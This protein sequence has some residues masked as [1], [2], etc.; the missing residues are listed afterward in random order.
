MM[1]MLYL[2]GAVFASIASLALA[3]EPSLPSLPRAFRA[4]VEANIVNKKYTTA[5]EEAYDYDANSVVYVRDVVSSTGEAGKS[6]SFHDLDQ[7]Q[8]WKWFEGLGGS[9]AR[10]CS[11]EYTDHLRLEAE[12][13]SSTHHLHLKGTADFFRFGA[14]F[15]QRFVGTS[16]VRG[17][18]AKWWRSEMSHSSPSRNGK[19]MV[20]KNYSLD[21]Y[22][23]DDDWKMSS[24]GSDARRLD[25]AIGVPLKL[26][27]TG[28]S[29]PLDKEAGEKAYNFDHH[30]D[31]FS[32]TRQVGNI[33]QVPASLVSC[34]VSKYCATL[35]TVDKSEIKRPL[36]AFDDICGSRTSSGILRL[37]EESTC[38]EKESSSGHA[39]LLVLSICI[40]GLAGAA[41]V[42]TYRQQREGKNLGSNAQLSRKD[43]L[44]EK[45][46]MS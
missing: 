21:Y 11:L 1:L 37:I 16:L 19:G 6:Y 4:T 38:P 18:P 40:L 23:V 43:S 14:K 17:I 31:Y 24:E 28:L 44:N 20:Q 39:I 10:E 42:W 46:E 25:D 8:H 5:L 22:F 13:S 45:I 30:Y 34:N 2:K 7:R 36:E 29:Y 9:P 32:F 12:E 35:L 26:R 41:S 27:L 3:D 33:L 15:K